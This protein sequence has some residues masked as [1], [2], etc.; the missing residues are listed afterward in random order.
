MSGGGGSTT[1]Q[2]ADPWSGV[3]QF[4]SGGGT[5]SGD[6]SA[7]YPAAQQWFTGA[8]PQYYGG[9]TVADQS[10]ETRRALDRANWVSEQGQSPLMGQTEDYLSN[11]LKGSGNNLVNNDPTANGSFLNSNPY[12]SAMVDAASRATTRNYTQAVVPGL[13][14]T[15][16]SGG[17]FGSA[18]QLGALSTSEQNLGQTL[19]DQSTNI[20]GQNY[21][22]ERGL[23]EAARARLQ[24]IQEQQKSQAVSL[25]PQ[26]SQIDRQNLLGNLDLQQN[27]GQQRDAYAQALRDAD[28]NRWNYNQNLPAQ[29]LQFY[30]QI[31]QGTAGLGGQTQT[32]QSGA[33]TGS[34]AFS[35][36]LGGAATGA[37]IGSAIPGVGTLI[38]GGVGGALGLLS[39][40]F[41]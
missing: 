17:R 18:A 19:S 13:N 39:G 22:Q 5:H 30:Q 21:A 35:G 3:Q 38:G 7:I 12:L 31:L 36:A 28:I 41:R 37:A 10:P 9:N 2:K 24:G 32:Q 29:K 11:I 33:S 1:T 15:F 25:L 23:M 40:F 26:L 8:G 14:S 27:V 4:L 6:M 16:A 20:Y 34:R